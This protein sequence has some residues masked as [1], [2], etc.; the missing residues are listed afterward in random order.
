MFRG[1][2][3]NAY[4]EDCVT[5]SVAS[6]LREVVISLHTWSTVPSLRLASTRKMVTN[7]IKFSGGHQD[8]YGAGAREVQ[9]EAETTGFGQS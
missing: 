1:N 4:R 8:D 5:R 9:G 3:G 7:W 2:R 6:R